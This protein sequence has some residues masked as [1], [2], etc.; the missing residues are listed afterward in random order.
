MITSG[1]HRRGWGLN[2][3]ANPQFSGIGTQRQICGRLT[4]RFLSLLLCGLLFVIALGPIY[5]FQA[6]HPLTGRRIAPVMGST[7]ADWLERRERE[8]EENPEGALNA[9]GIKPG[10]TVADVGAGIGYMTLRIAKRVGPTGTV[11][12][13]DVQPEMLRRLRQNAEA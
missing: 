10:M 7:G 3:V 13:N 11:Y 12:A 2:M 4:L 5:A 1:S 9:I 6:E 8:G